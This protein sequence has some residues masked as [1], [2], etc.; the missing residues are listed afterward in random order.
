LS[1]DLIDHW[2][3]PCHEKERL[4]VVQKLQHIS[5][6]NG[7]RV[8]FAAGDVHCGGFGRLVGTDESRDYRLMYQVVSSAIGNIPP[9]PAVLS[10]VHRNAKTSAFDA[11]TKEQMLDVFE[12]DVNSKVLKNKKLIGRR[13]WCRFEPVSDGSYDAALHVEDI[14]FKKRSHVYAINIPIIS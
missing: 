6:T 11:A 10:A 9:P 7:V 2:T 8:T 5:K 14:D 4:F 12:T 1:D 3:N 13:N